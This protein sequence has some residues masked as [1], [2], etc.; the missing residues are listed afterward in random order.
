MCTAP[1]LEI[2]DGNM[3]TMMELHTDAS[4]KALGA[5]LLQRQPGQTSFYPVTY[6]SCKFNVA[7]QNYSAADREMLA[8][9]ELLRH[10][11]PHFHGRKF[12][13]HTDHKPL[14]FFF[15]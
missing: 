8:I 6:Y 3:D 12:I 11:R 1:V 7:Q 10:W 4:A 2:Y 13:I 5:V 14:M 9:V 15:A